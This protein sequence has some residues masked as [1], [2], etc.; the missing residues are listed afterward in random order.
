[1]QYKPPSAITCLDALGPPALPWTHPAMASSWPLLSRKP[2]QTL[3]SS[4]TKVFLLLFPK[5]SATK[6]S[7][8]ASGDPES[9][10]IPE[11][12]FWNRAPLLE[13]SPLDGSNSNDNHHSTL[14]LRKDFC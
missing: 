5:L 13:Q 9:T 3:Y 1:M 14:L 4:L 2:L 11:P 10:A 7:H 8:S 6:L 12:L